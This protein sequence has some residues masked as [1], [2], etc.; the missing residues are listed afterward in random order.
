VKPPLVTVVIPAHDAERWLRLAL[1]SVQAQRW[2]DFEAIVVDDGSRDATPEIARDFARGDRRFRLIVKENGGVATA[3]NR[4]IREGRGELV[5]FLDA[6]D[7][8]LPNRLE[9]GVRALAR[10][11]ATGLHCAD[12]V[13]VDGEAEYGRWTERVRLYSGKV[14]ERLFVTNFIGTISVLVRRAVLEKTG[15]FDPRYRSCQDYDLWL[16]IA[17]VT[18]VEAEPVVVG[19]YRVT[20]GEHL[21]GDFRRRLANDFLITRRFLAARPAWAA[22]H[23]NAIRERFAWLHDQLGYEYFIRGLYPEARRELAAAL[24]FRPLS[25][26]AWRRLA[27]ACLPPRAI[28]R[29]RAARARRRAAQGGARHEE[30]VAAVT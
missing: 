16:R 11:K 8:W 21:S 14:L 15:L 1:E 17:E 13:W 23:R 2:E 4:A 25:L 9:L 7:E 3:R 5:A 28:L 22:A 30:P 26:R 10:R 19:R 12:E 18:E 27:A 20:P 6:D 24:C 29:I